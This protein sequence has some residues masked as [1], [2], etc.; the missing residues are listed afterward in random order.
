MTVTSDP[1]SPIQPVGSDVTLTC[2]VELSPAVDVP[3]AVNTVWTGPD[4]FMP[5]QAAIGS[6]T[7]FTSTATVSSFGRNQSGVYNC[8]CLLYT[9]DAADE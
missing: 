4:V 6:T 8:T 3:V 2:S 5:A 7:T 1:V 9:S